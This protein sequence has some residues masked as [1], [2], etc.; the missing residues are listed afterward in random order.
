M[1]A[2]VAMGKYLINDVLLSVIVS[3]ML[4]CIAYVASCYLVKHPVL[5][6]LK[7]IL[8]ARSID[9]KEL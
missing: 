8:K 2:F 5:L 3:C 4:G 6:E 7:S 9:N 1:V